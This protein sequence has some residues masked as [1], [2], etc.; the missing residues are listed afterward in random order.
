MVLHP[1]IKLAVLAIA[2][3]LC[4]SGM[5][6]GKL[7]C[8]DDA[9][10]MQVCGDV[11]PQ[12]C[13][14]RAYREIGASGRTLRNVAAPLTAEERAQQALEEAKRKEE[15]AALKEQQRKDQALLNTYGSVKDIEAMR[16]R[17]QDDVQ[18]SIA[19]AQEKIAEIRAQRKQYE[20]EAEFYKKKQL[21]AAVQKGLND[22]AFEITAQESIIESKQ[23]ELKIIREKYDEDK[24]RYID[25]SRRGLTRQ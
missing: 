20:D 18:R 16:S 5:A 19:A 2:L 22:T 10:G 24:R 7:Y 3:A 6:A 1:L 15:E 17:A 8:C 25:L 11:L 12:A 23:K 21:P 9:K 4:G 14:G 13:Y